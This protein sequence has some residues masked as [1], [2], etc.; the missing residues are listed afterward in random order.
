MININPNVANLKLSLRAIAEQAADTPGCIR[1]D[2]GMPGFPPPNSARTLIAALAQDDVLGY[3]S[4]YGDP[5][6]LAA[7]NHF[8]RKKFA[9]YQTPKTLITS[10][11]QA[12]LYSVF[13]TMLQP[14][15][16][17]MVPL[18]AYPPYT[19][20]ANILGAKT[21][22]SSPA[23][24]AKKITDKTKLI[25]LC[26][27]NNP[28]GSV[29][30]DHE[31]Q[32]IADVAKAHDLLILSDDVY[33][34]LWWGSEKIP[35]VSQYAPERTI[36]LNSVSKMLALPGFRTGWLIGEAALIQK[37]ALVHRAMNSCPNTLAQKVVAEL[38]PQSETF[39]TE[40]NNFYQSVTQRLAVGLQ[41]LSWETEIP[42]GGLYV[43]ARHDSITDGYAFVQDLI[44][45]K[46]ISAIPGEA[47]GENNQ[48]S[49]RFAAGAL[50]L[51]QVD[52]LLDR[53][54]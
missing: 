24:L 14:G 20:I 5:A 42:Q 23:D 53:L 30:S 2:L 10:G 38:L 21:V 37:I 32:I 26:A 28:S 15:D 51:E 31:L 54:K 49:I 47:F 36:C 8:E 46:K 44:Q 19:L 18:A 52:V 27:P 33:D 34:Q 48:G 1:A 4:L 9:A 41:K 16:E 40:A 45:H 3:A 17:V 50:S 22:A 11:G 6:C 39:L 43:W 7:I 25:V 29:Y 13:S 12:G 35:H